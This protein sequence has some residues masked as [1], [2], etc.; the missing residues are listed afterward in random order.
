MGQMLATRVI[1]TLLMKGDKLV[2]GEKFN[3]WRTVGVVA[4]AFKVHQ[5]RGV[6]EVCLLDV[7]ATPEGRG[8]DFDAIARLTDGCFSPVT[9][10]GGVRSVEDV[11]RLLASGADKVVI[12]TAIANVAHILKD[13]AERFGSQAIVAAVD[14]TM[15]SQPD[16]DA[17]RACVAVSC[18][19]TALCVDHD[20]GAKT[21]M[22]PIEWAWMCRSSGA[23]EILLTSIDR[24]GTMQGY[25]LDLI[26]A[27]SQAVS[28]PVIAHGGCSG[29]ED[30]VKAIEAGASACA[31]G[32]LF[33]FTE[34]TPADCSRYLNAH[35]IKARVA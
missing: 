23:G 26:R 8:P 14:Y 9:V 21:P 19:K 22:H 3:P 2:K 6:D 16:W 5:S 11:R 33:Q 7:A 34:T 15:V 25:D 17:P 10:G 13:C 35:G 24:E 27:V 28:V 30:M 12:G 1:P 32:A 18:G 31:A 29:P 4:Q 20:D